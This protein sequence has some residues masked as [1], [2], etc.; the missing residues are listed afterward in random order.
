MSARPGRILADLP[1]DL[2][3]PRSLASATAPEFIARSTEIRGLLHAR[4]G[5]D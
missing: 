3:R 2:P 5:I 4:G 1:I